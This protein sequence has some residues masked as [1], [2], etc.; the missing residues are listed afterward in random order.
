MGADMV[1][2]V[3]VPDVCM[4]VS[5]CVVLFLN[6]CLYCCSLGYTWAIEET[7]LDIGESGGGGIRD[8]QAH[9]VSVIFI[10]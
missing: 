4:R 1:M 6:K 2:R 8:E 10:T 5:S 3:D 7:T 9:G